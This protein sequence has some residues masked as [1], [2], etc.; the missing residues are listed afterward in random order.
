MSKNV[1]VATVSNVSSLVEI[2]NEI[3]NEKV[4]FMPS[5]ESIGI[6]EEVISEI[7]FEFE[8]E[9]VL[10]ENAYDTQ[11]CFDKSRELILRLII[12]LFFV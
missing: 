10:I 2:I 3:E 9:V 6:I 5:N 8:Y 4:Y 7:E 12:R 11:E 1:L